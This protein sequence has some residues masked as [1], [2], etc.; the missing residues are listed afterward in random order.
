LKPSEIIAAKSADL[1][2]TIFSAPVTRLED[3]DFDL[4]PAK[5]ILLR[6]FEVAS[7]DGYGCGN[8]PLAVRAAGSVLQY[9]QQTQK[10]ALSQL[11]RLSTYSPESFMALDIQTKPP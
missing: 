1:T 10:G 11:T 9:L 5:Q 4:E 2:A 7:L 8:L 6:H 3:Y